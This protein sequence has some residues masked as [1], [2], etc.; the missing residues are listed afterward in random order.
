MRGAGEKDTLGVNLAEWLAFSNRC[1]TL[2]FPAF[3]VQD[4]LRQRT[5]G[6]IAWQRLSNVRVDRD[7]RERNVFE[8]L[9]RIKV[10]RATLL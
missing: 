6:V 7:D 8:V 9:G 5:L 2:L 4:V 10:G 3:H 1:P